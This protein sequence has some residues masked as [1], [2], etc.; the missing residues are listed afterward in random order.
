M[1][2]RPRQERFL[3]CIL[4]V[5][6]CYNGTGNTERAITALFRFHIILL[7]KVPPFS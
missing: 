5:G 3:L 4:S 7:G 1:N 2:P 6:E